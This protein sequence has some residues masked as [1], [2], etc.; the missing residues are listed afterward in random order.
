MNLYQA[1]EP[2]LIK[3]KRRLAREGIHDLVHLE[4]EKYLRTVFWK[5]IKEWTLE[6]DNNRC[7]VCKA[8][9]STFCELE[10][11]HR[12]Y[13]LDVLEGRRS[14]MLVTLCPSCHKRVEFYPDGTK[15][16]C[17]NE[18]DERYFQLRTL[19]SEIEGKGLPLSIDRKNGESF[20][21]AYVGKEDYLQFYTVDAL[22]FGFVLDFY[23]RYRDQL[24]IPMPF[25]RDKFYQKTGARVSDRASSKEVFNAR[26]VDDQ[27]IIK[28]S[29]QCRFPIAEHFSTYVAEHG[30]WYVV[31]ETKRI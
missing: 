9:K 29:R 2:S 30:Y 19:H 15:R 27:S 28:A 12:S 23:H 16:T 24:K 21:V 22:M 7:V 5:E 11:H 13:D 14:E 20:D 1:V 6:R 31:K 3:L 4:Y 10:V 17:M 26:I 8:E 25:G 18:K